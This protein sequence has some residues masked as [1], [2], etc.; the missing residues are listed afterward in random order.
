MATLTYS[1][2]ADGN[3]ASFGYNGRRKRTM[4]VYGTWDGGTAKLQYT[5]DGGTTWI[6]EGTNSTF[7]ADGNVSM[8]QEAVTSAFEYRWNLA[9]AGGSVSLTFDIY[10]EDNS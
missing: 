1:L 2:T 4:A 6:D 7:T 8:N 9:G 5:P 10:D 3:T